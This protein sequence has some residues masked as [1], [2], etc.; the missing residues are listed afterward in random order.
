MNDPH[1][2]RYVRW[3][4]AELAHGLVEPE[5]NWV[6]VTGGT[7]HMPDH[8]IPVGVAWIVVDPHDSGAAVGPEA[9]LGSGARI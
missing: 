1:V 3:T 2:L 7:T 8:S 5:S 9:Q 4:P 6:T